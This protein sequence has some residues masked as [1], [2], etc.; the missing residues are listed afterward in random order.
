MLYLQIICN[1]KFLYIFVLVHFPTS[2]LLRRKLITTLLPTPLSTICK[3]HGLNAV[4]AIT[5]ILQLTLTKQRKI[6]T[7]I[8][9]A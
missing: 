3:V 4:P 9:A 2:T 6:K 7:I 8:T 1:Y 5:M